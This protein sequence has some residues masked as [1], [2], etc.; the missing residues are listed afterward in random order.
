MV[1]FDDDLSGGNRRA[2]YDDGLFD[3]TRWGIEY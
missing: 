3:I 1:V 2:I